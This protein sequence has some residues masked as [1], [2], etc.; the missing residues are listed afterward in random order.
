MKQN[1]KKRIP[2]MSAILI[3]A[4]S[5]LPQTVA[6]TTAENISLNNS[7][8][9]YDVVK[10]IDSQEWSD[11]ISLQCNANKADYESFLSN[12]NNEKNH[13][14][15]FNIISAEIIEIKEIALDDVSSFTRIYEYQEQYQQL[16]A[17][18]VGINYDVH[19]E[20][21]YYFDGVNYNLIITAIED[22]AWKI[23]EMSD[24]PIESLVPMGL[25]FNSISESK[26]LNIVNERIS[27]TVVDSHGKKIEKLST[28]DDTD[29]EHERPDYVRVYFTE[30]GEVEDID[31]YTYVKNVL[32]N[33]WYASWPSESLKA[34][35]LA[36]KMYGWYHTY[37]PK[38]ATLGADVKDTTADQVYKPNSEHEDTTAAINALDGIGLEN[39][40]GNIFE[41]QYNAGY[42]N[43]V[44]DPCTGKISQWGSKYFAD[45]GYDYLYICRYYY[46]ESDKSTGTV[47]TFEY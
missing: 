12:K 23:V 36:V 27:G 22:D 20:T 8:V 47:N 19:E 32:P 42:E 26:A 17:Y 34:G 11:Y 1:V 29:D 3:L 39:S 31:L 18:Y 6:A 4:T 45:E 10:A 38:W 43:T 9:V 21:K 30:I 35:A 41:T 33:E 37:H 5:F 24:A 2:L 16:S 13:K 14:G 25:G 40:D 28:K 15:L 7:N 44:G 46:D